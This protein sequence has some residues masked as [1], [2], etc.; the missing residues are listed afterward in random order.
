MGLQFD[1]R[2]RKEL[3]THRLYHLPFESCAHLPESLCQ[4]LSLLLE[5]LEV[6]VLSFHG[7]RLHEEEREEL[8]FPPVYEPVALSPYP[9]PFEPVY[10]PADLTCHPDDCHL[11]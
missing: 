10:G 8:P 9:F 1:K 3:L 2:E 6:W 11:S 4:S 5:W 7:V